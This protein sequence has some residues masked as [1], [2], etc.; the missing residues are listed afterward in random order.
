[1]NHAEAAIPLL[2]KHRRLIG[3]GNSILWAV[4]STVRYEAKAHR[5]SSCG[6]RSSLVEATSF[7]SP[8][9]FPR[10]RATNTCTYVRLR[11][12]RRVESMQASCTIC[13]QV[14]TCFGIPAARHKPSLHKR[15]SAYH[16]YSF[17]AVLSRGA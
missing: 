13:A 16:T 1:M 14:N 6:P 8:M 2:H 12:R 15:S 11:C 4:G 9:L 7:F 5:V 17:P 3:P 10:N